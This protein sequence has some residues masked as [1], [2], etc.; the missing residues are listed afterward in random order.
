MMETPLKNNLSENIWIASRVL[1]TFGYWDDG[2]PVEK[3]WKLHTRSHIPCH[4]CFPIR[5]FLG[6]IPYNKAAI[7]SKAL[8]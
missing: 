7:V 6:C 2:V 1:N 4:M 5:L 8:S 3:A